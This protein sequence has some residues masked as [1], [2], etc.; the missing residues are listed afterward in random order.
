MILIGVPR[1]SILCQA[2]A[3]RVNW[4]RPES[5]LMLNLKTG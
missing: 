2:L 4:V 5:V 3:Q 1:G